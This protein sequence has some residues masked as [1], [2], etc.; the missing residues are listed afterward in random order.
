MKASRQ[1]IAFLEGLLLL[2]LAVLLQGIFV[3]SLAEA[4]FSLDIGLVLI[5]LYSFRRGFKAGLVQGLF[6]G[7]ALAYGLGFFAGQAVGV[8]AFAVVGASLGL[9]GL[10]A[11]NLQ[12]TLYNRRLSSV[13][14]NLVTG[15]LLALLAFYLLGF[16]GLAFFQGQVELNILGMK[17]LGL[18]FLLNLGLSLVLLIL[19][20]NVS[21]RFFIPRQSPFISRRERSHLLND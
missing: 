7:L 2:I 19:M 1:L 9:A 12:R 6:Y 21:T 15:T 10:F 3:K 17:A 18:R 8:L 13:Y 4:G 5:L 20:L 14:L 11:R 16:L